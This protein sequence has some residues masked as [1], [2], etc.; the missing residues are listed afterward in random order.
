MFEVLDTLL[1]PLFRLNPLK[2]AF[3]KPYRRGMQSQLGK[4]ARYVFRYQ[5]LFAMVVLLLVAVFLITSW[6]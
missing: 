3:S 2:Y 5:V 6:P 1:G 4:E